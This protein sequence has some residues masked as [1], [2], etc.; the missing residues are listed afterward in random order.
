MR[1][2]HILDEIRRT[3]VT[4]GGKA[5]GHR[6]FGKRLASK[7]MNGLAAIGRGGVTLSAKQVT[8]QTRCQWP[9]PMT[10]SMESSH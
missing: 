9:L 6:E 7:K 2:E 1:K 10:C 4:N 5:L 8:N 3:A